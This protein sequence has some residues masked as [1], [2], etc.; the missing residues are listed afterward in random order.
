VQILPLRFE[1]AVAVENLHPVSTPRP[2]T[3]LKDQPSGNLAQSA[4]TQYLNL[5]LPT[6]IKGLLF[7]HPTNIGE[8]RSER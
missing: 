4:L 8:S 6:I 3:S 2:P 7:A 1:P 5:P